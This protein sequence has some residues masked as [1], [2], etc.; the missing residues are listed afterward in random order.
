[1]MHGTEP[2]SKKAMEAV[3]HHIDGFSRLSHA[4]DLHWGSFNR[5]IVFTPDHGAHLD[6]N[7]GRGT[8]GEDIPEDM[9]VCHYWGLRSGENPGWKAGGNDTQ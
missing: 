7:T 1:V 5:A 6:L 9:E 3:E 8:H 2:F 4:L